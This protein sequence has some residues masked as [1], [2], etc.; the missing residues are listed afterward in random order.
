[1]L[2]TERL[3]INPAT[4]DEMWEMISYAEGDVKC[5][6]SQMLDMAMADPER[7]IWYILWLIREK[8][9]GMMVGSLCFKG[10]DENGVTEIGYGI[11]EEYQGK[12]YAT[13]AVSAVVRWAAAQPGVN[14]IEAEAEADNA[15]SLR[16]LEKAGFVPNGIMGEEGPR[17]VWKKQ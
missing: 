13:E 7:W 5:A 8:D 11:E 9:S 15:P 1:M 17:F 14:V 10:L 6:F 3:T 12:G 2:N 4:D 16:V